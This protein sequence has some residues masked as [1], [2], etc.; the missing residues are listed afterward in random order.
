MVPF[1]FEDFAVRVT[2]AHLIP[3]FPRTRAIAL[4][5]SILAG[6][7]IR[8]LDNVRMLKRHFSFPVAL[9]EDTYPSADGFS[10]PGCHRGNR[11]DSL[12]CSLRLPYR[13]PR[14]TLYGQ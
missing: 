8:V 1:D 12:G 6:R 4:P 9:P 7:L 14:E 2:R 5:D 11:H 13:I 3:D 10:L